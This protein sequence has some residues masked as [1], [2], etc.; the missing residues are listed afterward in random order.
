[1][2][3]GNPNWGKPMEPTNEINTF[4]AL[5]A[6]LGLKEHELIDSEPLRSWAIRNAR[7]KYVPL[8]LLK[9]WRIEVDI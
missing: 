2:Q 1:M 6:K 7:S 3:R 8:E 5:V 4:D 9:A